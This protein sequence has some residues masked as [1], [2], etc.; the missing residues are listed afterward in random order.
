MVLGGSPCPGI[1]FPVCPE[2]TSPG[3]RT[4]PRASVDDPRDGV[5]TLPIIADIASP[6]SGERIAMSSIPAIRTT[7]GRTRLIAEQLKELIYAGEFKAGDRL[8]EAALAVR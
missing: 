7:E 8:N 5:D 6:S 1:R 3:R 2:S 4:G